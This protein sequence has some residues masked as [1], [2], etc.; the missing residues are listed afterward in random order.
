MSKFKRKVEEFMETMRNEWRV[1]N[2]VVIT[3]KEEIARLTKSNEGLM[4]RLMSQDFEKFKVYGT[5]FEVTANNDDYDPKYDANLA[6]EVVDL[7]E[8]TENR[9]EKA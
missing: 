2:A 8:I 5:D 9:T 6:G 7:D 3:L 1:Q 4:D